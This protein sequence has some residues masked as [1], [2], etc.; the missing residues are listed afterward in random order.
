M[1]FLNWF[2]FSFWVRPLGFWVREL[3]GNEENF[4][5]RQFDAVQCWLLEQHCTT[6]T[7]GSAATGFPLAQGRM[8]SSAY[9]FQRF[10]SWSM[11]GI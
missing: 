5:F 9:D 11:A 8:P 7:S 2:W 4:A 10:P 1:I 3:A 6:S